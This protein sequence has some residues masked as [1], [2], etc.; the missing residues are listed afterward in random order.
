MKKTLHQHK[1]FL[2]KKKK[3]IATC[4]KQ[5]KKDKEAQKRKSNLTRPLRGIYLPKKFF[6][7]ST[8]IRYNGLDKTKQDY[9]KLSP[10]EKKIFI[11]K[12]MTYFKKIEPQ[13]DK[14]KKLVKMQ[15][16]KIDS[17]CTDNNAVKRPNFRE[18]E[19]KIV[20]IFP[21]IFNYNLYY[22]VYINTENLDEL[23]I[24]QFCVGTGKM[25]MPNHYF[26][27]F[28]QDNSYFYKGG[29]LYVEKQVFSIYYKHTEK[30]KW[31]RPLNG[32]ENI[33]IM[34]N[35]L[36]SSPHSILYNWFLNHKFDD[37]I[38]E[39]SKLW[40]DVL[41]KI[42]HL[43]EDTVEKFRSGCLHFLRKFTKFSEYLIKDK[44]NTIYKNSMY[45]ADY[46][47]GI[48]LQTDV[49]KQSSLESCILRSLDPNKEMLSTD[50]T[51]PTSKT[52]NSNAFFFKS[53]ATKKT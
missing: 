35:A 30:D 8:Y 22:T 12:G 10:K 36:H 28:L 48:L 53:I 3:W 44:E 6:G 11:K 29:K 7:I 34:Y 14:V 42:E 33:D 32:L 15:T 5:I 51:I 23:V 17:I 40:V 1:K 50:F 2:K 47:N 39:S 31:Y 19:T 27:K 21:N 41:K 16:Q 52:Q 46:V 43:K 18:S 20:S 24:N 49:S 13:D 4:I 9:E 37:N 45:G 26:Y 25:R 38:C